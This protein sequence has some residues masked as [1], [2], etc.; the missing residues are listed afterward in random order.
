MLVGYKHARDLCKYWLLLEMRILAIIE[1]ANEAE[2][3]PRHRNDLQAQLQESTP[4]PAQLQGSTP[5]P[6]GPT[7]KQTETSV[8][9]ITQYF[10]ASSSVLAITQYFA[11]R[12]QDEITA[13]HSISI[14]SPNAY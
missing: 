3:P 12:P 6:T 7:I 8:L 11:D 13:I 14:D 2:G 10:A 1:N 9:A 5:R 4:R